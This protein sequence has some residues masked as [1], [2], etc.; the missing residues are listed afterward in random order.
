M[1]GRDT[2][3]PPTAA[4][5]PW[6][7]MG[8]ML[9]PRRPLPTIP[10]AQIGEPAPVLGLEGMLIS[11][12]MLTLAAQMFLQATYMFGQLLWVRAL[13]RHVLVARTFGQLSRVQALFRRRL[14]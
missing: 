13:F 11:F 8:F 1:C 4:P 14:S 3:A 6:T 5:I 7:M 12:A 10:P 9:G 2:R